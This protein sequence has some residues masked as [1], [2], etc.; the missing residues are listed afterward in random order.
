MVGAIGKTPGRTHP[1]VTVR[2]NTYGWNQ[3][4]PEV[5]NPEVGGFEIELAFYGPVE[6]QFFRQILI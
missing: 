4:N 1:G 3:W 5:V 6:I 2:R